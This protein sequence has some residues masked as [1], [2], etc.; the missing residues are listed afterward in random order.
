MHLG[1]GLFYFRDKEKK[2]ARDLGGYVNTLR[3]ASPQ[4]I[5]TALNGVGIDRLS[6]LG[7][8]FAIEVGATTGTPTSFTVDAKLQESAD[9]TTF[10]DIAGATMTQITAANSHGEIN[11][12]LAGIKRYI[13]AV[14]TPAF[15]GGTAP[16][17]LV[18]ASCVLG[19]AS[20]LPV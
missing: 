8:V 9:N 11:L 3:E 5:S 12:N 1:A 17:V 14:I 2:M 4:A 13:R 20:S 15:V 19:Q 18:G 10:T 7:A 6:Y 16:T